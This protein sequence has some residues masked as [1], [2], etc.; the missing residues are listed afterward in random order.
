M[1]G[2]VN[3]YYD[4]FTNSLLQRR[5]DS[6]YSRERAKLEHMALFYSISNPAPP[7]QPPDS[8]YQY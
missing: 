5:K 7:Y 6:M 4:M 3:Y 8:A 2:A 1:Q